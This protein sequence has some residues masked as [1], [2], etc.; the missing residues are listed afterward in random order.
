M[1]ERIKVMLPDRP[2]YPW[3][4]W[5]DGNAWQIE[6]GTDFLPEPRNFV[7]AMHMKAKKKGMKLKTTVDGK[8]IQFQFYTVEDK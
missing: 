4:E 1:G 8:K 5:M 6:Q 7:A 3:D 2:T